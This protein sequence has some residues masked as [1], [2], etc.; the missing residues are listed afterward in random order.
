[1][2]AFGE[3]VQFCRDLRL[4]ERL[5]VNQRVLLVDRVVLGLKKEGWRGV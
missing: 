1:M 5:E 4:F 3:D 2:A